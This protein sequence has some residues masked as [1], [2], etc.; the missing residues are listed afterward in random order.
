M[1]D[2]AESLRD[3]ILDAILETPDI[4]KLDLADLETLADRIAEVVYERLRFLVE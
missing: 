3:E 2:L 4:Q 1:S